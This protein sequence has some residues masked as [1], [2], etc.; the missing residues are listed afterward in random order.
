[1]SPPFRIPT[2]RKP[3]PP[4]HR[5]RPSLVPRV[6]DCFAHAPRS[7][8]TGP[9]FSNIHTHGHVR[10]DS[11]TDDAL[12][13]GGN[14]A[15]TPN[16]Q[17][18]MC[19]HNPRSSARCAPFLAPPHLALGGQRDVPVGLPLPVVVLDPQAARARDALGVPR[20]PRAL[21]PPAPPPSLTRPRAGAPPAAPPRR[22]SRRPPPTRRRRPPPPRRRRPWRPF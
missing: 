21:A 18:P 15:H 9:F 16:A 5:N 3:P 2:P 8:L 10:F 6:F 22:S 19:T 13:R 17:G 12:H 4:P 7:Y 20:L 11:T 14:T 1:M